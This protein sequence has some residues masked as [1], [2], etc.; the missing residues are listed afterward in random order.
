MHA[1]NETIERTPKR[2][3]FFL[4]RLLFVFSLGGR[5]EDGFKKIL[6][7]PSCYQH[8]LIFSQ[9]SQCVPQGSFK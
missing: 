2:L 6:A 5:E 9:G 7:F 3:L 1:G 8:V 4:S